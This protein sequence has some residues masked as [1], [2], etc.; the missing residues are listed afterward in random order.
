ME[1]LDAAFL[2]VID[3]IQNHTKWQ[4]D[5]TAIVCGERRV[6]YREFGLAVNR[7]ANGLIKLGLK[8]GDKVSIYM[9]NSI[10]C[11]QTI[12]G[13]IAA[14]CVA[15]PLSGMQQPGVLAMMINDSDSRALF[16]ESEFLHAV[17]STVRDKMTGIL[18][19]GFFLTGFKADGWKDFSAWI[20]EQPDQ[21][22]GIVL[23]PED[24]FNIIYS[25][26]TTGAPKGIV[27]THQSRFM[28]A[29]GLG[30]AFRM[31]TY[32]VALITTPIYTNGTWMMLLPALTLGG[33]LVIMPQFGMKLFLELVQ[34]ERCTHTFMVPTQFI[35]IMADPDFGSYDLSSL[36]IALSAAAP[37]RAETKREIIEKFGV[38]LSELYGLTEGIGTILNPEEMAGKTGSVGRPFANVDIKIVNDAG[39]E[40]PRGQI[41]EIAGYGSSMMKEYYKKPD[42]TAE[43]ILRDERG[44]TYLKTGDMGKLDSDGFLYI[45]DRKKDMILSGGINVFAAD[46][47]NIIAG[48]PAVAD[49]TVIA[50]PHEKWGESPLA[51]VVPRPGAALTEEELMN[52]ANERLAKYQRLARVEFRDSLPRNILGKVMKRQLREPFWNETTG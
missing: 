40:L 35:M 37:L 20:A 21:P 2:G 19:G 23:N 8:K 44:R 24:D 46:L 15:V 42:K 17:I 30:L 22:P 34:K 36:E 1:K 48:H 52:W 26:G 6:S 31:H 41:G 25:S 33:T 51:L 32:A 38:Q 47:E 14:G 50:I 28:F 12:F 4:P 16:V 39:V 13:V 5:K 7:I 49:N 9:G 43:C 18:E 11:L 29:M 10:E 3:C 27:H 45:L